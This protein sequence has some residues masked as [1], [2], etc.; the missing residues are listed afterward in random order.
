MK[1]LKNIIIY[2]LIGIGLGNFFHL[3]SLN[4]SSENYISTFP[5]FKEMFA[6]ELSAVTTQNIIYAIIGVI[7][8]FA[9]K[10]FRTNYGLLLQTVVHYLVIALPLIL[11]YSF[12]LG[13]SSLITILTTINFI[14]ILVYI[15]MYLHNK[16]KI[17]KINAK[18]K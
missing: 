5:T 3:L 10:I 14:Y 12:F 16:N 4:L 2:V 9:S 1:T 18:L 6:S 13:G 11:L 7:Q 17:N 8:G 15:F